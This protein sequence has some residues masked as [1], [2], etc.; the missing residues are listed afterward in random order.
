[1]RG[2]K[3][4]SLAQGSYWPYTFLTPPMPKPSTPA[5]KK[6]KL[7]GARG[8]WERQSQGRRNGAKAPRRE[9]KGVGVGTSQAL[10]P[11][12]ILVIRPLNQWKVGL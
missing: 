5:L 12:S 3:T 1:M 10:G 8:R 6:G 11:E 4:S 7:L 2:G 9:G